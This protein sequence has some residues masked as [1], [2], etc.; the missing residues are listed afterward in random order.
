MVQK[1]EV[2]DYVLA[3]K[4]GDGDPC[5]HFFVGFVSEY[6][7]HG[8]YLIVDNEG[9]NQRANGFRRV[10]RLTADEGRKLVE[11]MPSIGDRDGPS[12]WW[13]L[14]NIRGIGREI[15]CETCKYEL[16]VCRCD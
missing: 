6:T 9:V 15:F 11:L 16:N 5:D 14:S 7:H 3:T 1:A 2:G 4:Y 10:E 12:L 13:H 8:R